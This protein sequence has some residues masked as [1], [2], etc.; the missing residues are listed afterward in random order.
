MTGYANMKLTTNWQNI[1]IRNG[2]PISEKIF[3]DNF[4]K[5]GLMKNITFSKEQIAKEKSII[6]NI[7][8]EVIQ[9]IYKTI[10][11]KQFKTILMQEII[12]VTCRLHRSS[13]S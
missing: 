9:A 2:T 3:Q 10:L 1:S 8:N 12:T 13:I 11:I 7:N 5:I 6:E 4:I